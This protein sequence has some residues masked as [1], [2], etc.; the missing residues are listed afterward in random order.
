MADTQK[1]FPKD[2]WI[3]D[4]LLKGYLIAREDGSILRAKRLN[5]DGTVDKSRGYSI[6]TQQTHKKSGRVYFNVTWRGHT[7]SVLTNRVV[8]L[9]FHK[10]PLNMPQVNHID[11]IKSNNAKDNLEWATGSQNEKHAHETGLKSNRGSG[12][13]NS[14][15]NVN[16]VLAIR[17]SHLSVEELAEKYGIGLTTVRSV[18]SR[19]TWS[20][21]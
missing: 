18:I 5:K 14:K 6:I 1:K 17:A 13:S 19:R 21:V 10:N 3:V 2:K 16:D 12:N 9:R 8:A 15:L 11:G 4:M 20:H 7:K